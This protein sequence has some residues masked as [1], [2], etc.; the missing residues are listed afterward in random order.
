V[1]FYFRVCISSGYPFFQHHQKYEIK[2]SYCSHAT[3]SKQVFEIN[4]VCPKWTHHK[5]QVLWCFLLRTLSAYFRSVMEL[6][7][8]SLIKQRWHPSGHHNM[9]F[10]QSP[11]VQLFLP[12]LLTKSYENEDRTQIFPF[13]HT[14]ITRRVSVYTTL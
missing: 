10:V 11:I 3:L 8:N 1:D 2:T 13:L 9:C 7:H 14:Q 5:I 6:T 4:C 12:V